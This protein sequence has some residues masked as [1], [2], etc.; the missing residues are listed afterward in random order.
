MA[1]QDSRQRIFNLEKNLTE[2]ELS[3]QKSESRA[4]HLD[5][6]LQASK[7]ALENSSIGK[8]TNVKWL[9]S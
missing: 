2:S 3:L 7:S 8:D 1:L 6:S 9:K 5:L 4:N